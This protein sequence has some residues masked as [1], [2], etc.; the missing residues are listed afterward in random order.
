MIIHLPY[1]PSTNRLWRIAG[2][3]LHPS[4][5]SI[6]FKRAVKTAAIDASA[7]CLSGDIAVAVTLH[8]RLT[9]SGGASMVR[10]DLDNAIKCAFDGGNGALWHDDKQIA[11]IEAKVGAPVPGGSLTM[12]VVTLT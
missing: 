10:I 12:E 7:V 6:K 2:N 9:K 1:P 4:M 8:P 3:R 5:E 11:L